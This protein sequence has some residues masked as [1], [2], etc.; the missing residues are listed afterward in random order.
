MAWVALAG[1]GLD[2]VAVIGGRIVLSRRWPDVRFVKMQVRHWTMSELAAAV[3]AVAGVATSVGGLVHSATGHPGPAL[4]SGDGTAALGV[5]LLVAGVALTVW[6]QLSMGAS[7]RVG[8]DHTETTVLL[9]AGPYRRIRNPI[10]TA[11]ILVFGGVV[12]LVPSLVV[13]VG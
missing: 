4:T 2:V 10:Y 1:L 11:M 5:A 9:R 12:V 6:S 3:L 7:W 13:A 8:V